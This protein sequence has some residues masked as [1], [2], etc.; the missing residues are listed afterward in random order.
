MAP[1]GCLVA[2]GRV[3]FA[4][5]TAN[6]SDG[7]PVELG[8]LGIPAPED[9]ALVFRAYMGALDDIRLRVSLALSR[10]LE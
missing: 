1:V 6:R 10:R 2:R 8:G 9:R 5:A 4:C 3:S 7:T